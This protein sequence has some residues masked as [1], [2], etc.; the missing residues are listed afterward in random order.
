MLHLEKANIKHKNSF[1]DAVKEIL[2]GNNDD[3]IFYQELDIEYLNNNFDEYVQTI[4][5]QEKG[6]GLKDGYVP[7]TI[8]WIIN[9]EKYVGRIA[10]RHKLNEHLEK[11][12][13]HIGYDIIPSERNKGYA[14]KALELCLNEAKKLGITN[15]LI[16]C[17][18]DNLASKKVIEKNGGIY[19]SKIKRETDNIYILKYLIDL[20]E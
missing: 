16:S 5:N 12:D 9:D 20:T 6:I 3:L 4:L 14:S 1:L 10:L 19:Q 7:D 8:F 18:E 2:N 17:N 13:G 15:I 11:Y